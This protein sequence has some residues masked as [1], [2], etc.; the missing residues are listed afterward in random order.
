MWVVIGSECMLFGTL[1]IN[2]IISASQI[3]R[4]PAPGLIKP[5]EIFNILV[6]STSTFVL[7][8]SSLAMVLCHIRW[9]QKA[10]PLC[11]KISEIFYHRSIWS[12][13]FRVSSL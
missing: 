11:K 9:T 10:F 2:Y 5:I 8:M 13:I 7:L 4:D 6:T 12:Y 1:I 3:I